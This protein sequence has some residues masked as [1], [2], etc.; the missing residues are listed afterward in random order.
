MKTR[1]AALALLLGLAGCHSQP[2][3]GGLSADDERELD[4]AAAMLDRQNIFAAAPDGLDENQG[5]AVDAQGNGVA[6]G[7]GSGNGQ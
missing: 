6:P 4:N 2:T 5:E 1:I 7:N 3:A